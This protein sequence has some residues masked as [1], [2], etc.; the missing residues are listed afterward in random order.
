MWHF[1]ESR[2][3]AMRRVIRTVPRA[4]MDALVADDWPGNIRELQNVIERALI[5]SPGPV[6]QIDEALGLA[7]RGGRG[8]GRNHVHEALHETE[9]AHILRILQRCNWMIEGGGR[10][11]YAIVC[12]SSASTAPRGEDGRG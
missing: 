1:I 6:L 12:G 7:A 2:Q 5:L 4:A 11:R 8:G 10:A 3:R 9:R